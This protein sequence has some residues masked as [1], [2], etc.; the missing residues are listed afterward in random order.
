MTSGR[1]SQVICKCKWQINVEDLEDSYI[2]TQDF[3]GPFFKL[4]GSK[5]S[6]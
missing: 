3:S 6:L 4:M 1:V 5:D 2:V